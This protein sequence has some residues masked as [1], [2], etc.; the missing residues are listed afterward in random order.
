MRMGAMDVANPL[1]SS[2]STQTPHSVALPNAGVNR[3][4]GIFFTNLLIG[5][6]FSIPIIES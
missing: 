3:P 1:E 4:P 5:S 2:V 6:S